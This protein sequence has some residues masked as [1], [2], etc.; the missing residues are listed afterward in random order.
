MNSQYL[1]LRD[2]APCS[3]PAGA[4]SVSRN[5]L[6][7][8]VLTFAL[9]SGC[10]IT[11]VR[12]APLKQFPAQRGGFDSETAS[13][14]VSTR[15]K[16]KLKPGYDVVRSVPMSN[17]GLERHRTAGIVTGHTA[18]FDVAIAGGTPRR[19]YYTHV[20]ADQSYGPDGW[21]AT[22]ISVMGAPVELETAMA[23]ANTP[24]EAST[25]PMLASSQTNRVFTM[26]CA[27]L[28]H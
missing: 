26:E 19:C 9:M 1:V 10:T 12:N 17:W 22:T 21:G 11:M 2:H 15:V 25:D 27:A 16:E 7:I 4:M 8:L 13:A 24:L 3:P 14:D 23:R 20:W 6:P 28:E 5:S 18:G